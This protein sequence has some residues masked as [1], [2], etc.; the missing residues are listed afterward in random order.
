MRKYGFGIDIG[1]TKL[2]FGII[3]NKGEVLYEAR[4]TSA[5]LEL[6]I[7]YNYTK[8]TIIITTTIEI[9]YE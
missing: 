9:T 2:S 1:G 6:I 7:E 5:K 4:E 3:N 8:I